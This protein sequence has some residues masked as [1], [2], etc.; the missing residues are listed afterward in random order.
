VK[1]L[2]VN[3]RTKPR[4]H[5]APW[6]AGLPLLIAALALLVSPARAAQPFIWDDDEDGID[7]RIET[8][9][10]LGYR[11]SF[12]GADTLARQRFVVTPAAQL[13]YGVY[14]IYEEPVTSADLAA[15]TALGM[16]VT[17]RYTTLPAVRSVATFAQASAARLLPGVVRVEAIPILYPV[18]RENLASA[19][20]RDPSLEVWPT[21]TGSGGGD[22]SG[23]VVGLL[24][25]GV[26]DQ[27]AS[28]YPG[29]ESLAG[30]VI[31]GAS[32]THGD[33][34]LD[35]PR[36]GSV[37]PEDS[38]GSL[39][40]S[41]GTH[42]AGIVLGS[43][44]PSGY[45]AGV[46]PG[47]KLIDIRVLS[48]AGLGTGVSEA[49]D[50]CCWNRT[51]NWGA[52]AE[53]AGI[54]VINLSLSSL[55]E[56][57]GQDFAARLAA[58]AVELGIVVVASMGNE[59]ETGYVP[60]PAAGDGVIAVG[61][62]DAGRT[63]RGDDDQFWSSS[64]AGPRAS[65]GDLDLADEQKPDLVAPGV[66]VLSADGDF[67]TD[68]DQYVRLTGTSMSAAVVTGVVAALRSEFPSLTPAAIADLLRRTAR[69]TLGGVPAGGGGV[70]PRWHPAIGWGA[71]DLYAARTELLQ[72]ERTQIRRLI[73]TATHENATLE[74]WTQRERGAPHVV[75]ERALDQG[76]APGTFAPLD[77]LPAAG[78]SSL[79]VANLHA[80]TI[81]RAVAPEERGQTWW[82]RVATVEGGVRTVT[83]AHVLAVPSGPPVARIE[84]TIVHNAFDSDID[85][86]VGPGAAV[87]GGRIQGIPSFPLPGSA[88]AVS[89]DWVSGTSTLGNIAW[90]F[91]IP[92]P[93]GEAEG[94]LPPSPASP[95]DLQVTEGGFLNR[96]GRVTGF[97]VI[98]YASGGEVVYEG[99]PLPLQTIEGSTIHVIAPSPLSGAPA[100]A[101]PA[102]FTLGPNP[103][104]AGGSVRFRTTDPGATR[105]RIFDLSGREVGG[106]D[107]TAEPSG[108]TGTWSAR[109]RQGDPL[110]SGLYFAR[111][112]RHSSRI[113][114]VRR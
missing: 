65:D 50:W 71:V 21:W 89:S 108:A 99:Q 105:V 66:A 27:A 104:D 81:T 55:D 40:T 41:H 11:F 91:S 63:G 24:D 86:V 73:L 18:T 46:A 32:F 111:A 58:R 14:V 37:N 97:R 31:G 33:S 12:E 39:G 60:S 22:G 28:N 36:N 67:A 68:G 7:D 13:A 2:P 102:S 59:G 77:S 45:A 103:V 5:R 43:G 49:L 56:S 69:R 106:I 74:A 4:P 23:V 26:N 3:F 10:L 34:A 72:P 25:T 101:A 54:D 9:E 94:F 1:I 76:G 47:A 100:P 53:Y 64:D 93:A 75:F 88:S 107:L 83:P 19:G 110:P 20:V 90:S 70:D 79:A 38:G 98:W 85:A 82:I 6:G 78:D 96:S 30:R 52:G 112:G 61:C 92:V 113:A 29:H 114:V 95:W 8:V 15:L 80:Y 51:R 17:W 44:G 109:N 35:T 57:D 48:A 16:P 84:V 62:Y 42:V 87:A